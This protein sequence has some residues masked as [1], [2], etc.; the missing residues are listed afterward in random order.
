[1]TT[2]TDT[3]SVATATRKEATMALITIGAQVICRDQV[4]HVVAGVVT[5][6]VPGACRGGGVAMVKAVWPGK[7]R[8]SERMVELADVEVAA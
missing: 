6:V 5:D 3:Y 8:A 7:K 4:G 1:M 2:T